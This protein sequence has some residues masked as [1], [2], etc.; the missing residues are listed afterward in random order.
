MT[1]NSNA[2]STERPSIE[3]K[4]FLAK[5][6]KR[7]STKPPSPQPPLTHPIAHAPGHLQPSY[8]VPA[9]PHPC[10]HEHISLLIT[11]EGLLL[12]P[13]V[14]GLH[15][16]SYVRI[17]WGKSAQLEEVEGNAGM[18]WSNGVVVYGILGILELSSGILY[19]TG[20]S[21]RC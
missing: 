16:K 6:S 1:F 11:S 8:T 2:I 12:R 13:H 19:C 17:A 10:P 18:D 14:A 9:V 7:A 4:N 3:M 5:V 20:L 15:P 21:C